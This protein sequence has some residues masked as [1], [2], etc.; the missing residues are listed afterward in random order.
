MN[1]CTAIPR[2]ILVV[3]IV[4]SI[5]GLAVLAT[6]LDR[7][8]SAAESVRIPAGDRGVPP[9]PPLAVSEL[10]AVP[11]DLAS[12][13]A[14]AA[15]TSALGS[16]AD[17]SRARAAEV[18]EP[19][20]LAAWA[21]SLTDPR[22]GV[23]VARNARGELRVVTVREERPGV[24]ALGVGGGTFELRIG[25]GGGGFELE[26]TPETMRSASASSLLACFSSCFI[27]HVPAC[28]QSCRDC[29]DSGF[30]Q[31][32]ACDACLGYWGIFCAT[33]C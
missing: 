5:L 18:G 4:V 21:P 6:A 22:A 33:T 24:V 17:V 1:A 3:S 32:L 27:Q 28:A 15:V 26:P 16:P 13:L 12:A 2:R 10:P 11:A 19:R 20:V 8:S 29:V 25:P 23:A 7:T 14:S 9:G 30:T 31:C